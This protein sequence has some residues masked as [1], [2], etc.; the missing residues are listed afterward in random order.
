MMRRAQDAVSD[1]EEGERF[2]ITDINN[3]GASALAQSGIPVMLDLLS[4]TP[5]EFNHIPGGSN[6]LYMDGRVAFLCYPS[7]FPA[8]RAF[9]SL[10]SML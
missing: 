7:V 1:E 10:I 3:P 5:S 9:A 6:V 2:F 8:T 4:T